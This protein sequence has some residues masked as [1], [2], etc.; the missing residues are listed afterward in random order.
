MVGKKIE[1]FWQ[2]LLFSL[3]SPPLLIQNIPCSFLVVWGKGRC[4]KKLSPDI[5]PDPPSCF[6]ELQL[7]SSAQVFMVNLLQTECIFP[8]HYKS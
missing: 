1:K 5:L 2:V 8:H 4:N 7:C 3:R 6:P